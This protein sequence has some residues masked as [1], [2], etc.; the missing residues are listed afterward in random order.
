MDVQRL[1]KRMSLSARRLDGEAV[2][3]I[4]LGAGV[5]DLHTCADGTR[6]LQ[7]PLIDEK[8]DAVRL[9]NG[10][11]ARSFYV[12][13]PPEETD[14]GWLEALVSF[15]GPIHMALHIEGLDQ[16]RERKRLKRRRRREIDAAAASGQLWNGPS[17]TSSGSSSA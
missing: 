12:L 8:Q 15:N 6:L 4:L 3:S 9:P 10:T 11:W 16:H 5:N 17:R 2:R 14:P 1:L 13:A 7:R